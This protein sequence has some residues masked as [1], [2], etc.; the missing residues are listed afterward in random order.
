MLEAGLPEEKAEQLVKN[1]FGDHFITEWNNLMK[2]RKQI[3]QKQ[4]KGQKT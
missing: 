1:V 4:L 3:G 2:M